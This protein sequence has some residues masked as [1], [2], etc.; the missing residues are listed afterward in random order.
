MADIIFVVFIGGLALF[1]IVF[2][3]IEVANGD[4]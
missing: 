2:A 3:I 1:A 4:W